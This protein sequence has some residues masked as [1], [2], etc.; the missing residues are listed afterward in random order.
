MSENKKIKICHFAHRLTGKSDGI[1]T[2]LKMLFELL[3]KERFEQILIY[4]GNEENINSYCKNLGIKVYNIPE[5]NKKVPI[6]L[7]FKM[8]IIFK[9]ENI[10]IIHTHLV[11]PYIFA[12][13]VNLFL[14]KK[15][16][17][18]YQGVFLTK[19]YY[20]KIERIILRLLHNI[21][22][23]KDGGKNILAITPSK[24][25]SK[26]L[27]KNGRFR[28]ILHYYNG[29]IMKTNKG[30][31]DIKVVSYF[32]KLKH[33]YFLL[34]IVARHEKQK[35]L[36]IAL[37]ILK[38]LLKQK[39]NVFFVFIGDGPQFAETQN[40]ANIIGVKE[41]CY[42]IEYLNDLPNYLHFFDLILFTSEWEGFPLTIWEA[43]YNEVPVVSS[44]V[45]GIKEIFESENCGIVYPF[46]DVNK[47]VN[48]ISDLYFNRD[49]LKELGENGRR[50]I[51]EK[52]NEKTFKEFFVHLYTEI[53]NEK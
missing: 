9:E 32:N 25:S 1:F 17:F 6:K 12:G 5:L 26:E 14:N 30:A 11:K 24:T 36:D 27:E 7:F 35:R 47:C 38:K 49:K 2:H 28:R 16:I 39:L 8:M 45:G 3:D 53:L 42:F 18:N 41:R 19:K 31:I 34:G 37:E 46:A 43:M 13:L 4:S 29:F 52:Y 48:I 10:D 51:V 33:N 23:F 44:D 50:A 40:I 15:L 22:Q 20:S 21:L